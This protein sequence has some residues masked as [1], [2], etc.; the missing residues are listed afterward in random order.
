[1]CRADSVCYDL[2]DLNDSNTWSVFETEQDHMAKILTHHVEQRMLQQRIDHVEQAVLH[3][4]I[5]E[6]RVARFEA[7]IPEIV[8]GTRLGRLDVVRA[9]ERMEVK[10]LVA[11]R[12]RGT[13]RK[14]TRYYYLAALKELTQ[15]MADKIAVALHA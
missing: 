6:L 4:L 9:L 10:E 8:D 11:F 3:F 12:T 5:E 15:N 1:V 2:N 14:G 7:T 13:D